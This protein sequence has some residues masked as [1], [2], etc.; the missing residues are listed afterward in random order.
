MHL[1][2]ETVF[3]EEM[4]M[5][6]LFLAVFLHAIFNICLEMGWVF[7]MVPFLVVGYA[8]LNHL[9]KKKEDQKNYGHLLDLEKEDRQKQ[10]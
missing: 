9:F 7:M 4:M 1:K 10:N 3:K 8:V 5:E 2:S 6:G